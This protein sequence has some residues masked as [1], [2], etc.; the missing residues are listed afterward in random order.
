MGGSKQTGTTTTTANSAPWGPQQPFLMGGFERAQELAQGTPPQ[1]FPG[2]TYASPTDAQN[3]ALGGIPN[4]AVWDLGNANQLVNANTGL[5]SGSNIY[6][7]PALAPLAGLSGTNL[8]ANN[9]GTGT[10]LSQAGGVANPAAGALVNQAYGG[11]ANPAAGWLSSLA[12]TNLGANNAG[13]GTLLSQAYNGVANPAAGTLAGLSSINPA[14]AGPWANALENYSQGGTI[15]AAAQAALA[16]NSGYNLGLG[17]PSTGALGGYTGLGLGGAGTLA[18]LSSSN[19]AGNNPAAGALNSYASGASLAQG[20][21]NTSALAQQVMSQVAPQIE[22][23]FIQGGALSNPEAARATAAGVTSALAPTLAQQFQQEQANQILAGTTLGNQYLQGLGLQGSLAGTLGGLGLQ[24]ASTLGGQA[25]TGQQN[26]NA[27]AQA[28]GQLGLAGQQL[29]ASAAGTLGGLGVQGAGVQAGAAGTLGNQALQGAGLQQ[30]AAGTLGNQLLQGGALQQQAAGTLGG[31]ALQGAGLQQSA[32]GT[33]G[34]QALQGAGLQQQAAGTLGNQLIQGGAL[35]NAVLQNLGSTYGQ[36]VQQQLGALSLAP[37][38]QQ[39][40]YTDLSQ[41]YSGGATQQAL[42]QASIN[43]A[44]QRWNYQQQLPYTI[45]NQYL[46]QVTGNYGGTSQLNQPIL[47]NPT[48]NVLGGLGSL[49]SIGGSLFGPLGMFGSDRR[50]KKDIRVIGMIP[51]GLPVYAF[52]Y[53]GADTTNIGLMADE[54]EAVHPEAVVV[55]PLGIKMVDY[56]LAV[57]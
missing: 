14:M 31:Q 4:Q 13:T 57:Q 40:P 21:P 28:L 36:G 50:I 48:A 35:Q 15:P 17:N 3:Q 22:S 12:G 43:D 34:N 53:V 38:M 2:A 19:I 10:L 24:G 30:Q 41:L 44:I 25:L 52:K 49:A 45:L 23:Q 47:N 37:Q 11:I 29:G 9:A 1:Y 20:N 46:G 5:A 7:N 6:N 54:V 42:Q 32:A 55:G 39:M 16:G 56:A 33:L 51:N 26:Q 8:G 27:A 18:N